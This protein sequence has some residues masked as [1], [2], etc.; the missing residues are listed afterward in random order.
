ML[1]DEFSV[2]ITG[3][4]RDQEIHRVTDKTKGD[5]RADGEHHWFRRTDGEIPVGQSVEKREPLHISVNIYL[6]FTK[7]FSAS[8][9][10]A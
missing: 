3:R 2:E 6:H 8:N 4:V 7:I 9:H 5:R 10:P 1:M